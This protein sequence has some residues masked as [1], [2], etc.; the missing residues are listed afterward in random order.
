MWRGIR[1]ITAYKQSD[2]QLSHDLA[3]LDTLN[4]FFARFDTPSSRRTKHPPQLEVQHQPLVLQLHQ[5]TSIMRKI[6]INK[7]ADLEMMS[8]RTLNSYAEQLA[9][10]F[11][12]LQPTVCLQGESLHRGCCLVGTSHGPDSS[13]APQ[14]LC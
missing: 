3:L 8:G 6:N 2:Q 14:Y 5:V 13:G 9:G 10:F 11:G 7:A 12:H 1:S 4:S